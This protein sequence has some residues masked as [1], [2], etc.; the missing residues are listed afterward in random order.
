MTAKYV[1]NFKTRK[2]APKNICELKWTVI[3]KRK[4]RKPRTEIYLMNR[5]KCIIWVGFSWQILRWEGCISAFTKKRMKE[6]E[7]Q[8]VEI[9]VRMWMWIN[10]I[11][12]HEKVSYSVAIV[13]ST[14]DQNGHGEELEVTSTFGNVLF[15]FF[16]FIFFIESFE[17]LET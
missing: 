11:N 7:E 9:C 3:L 10:L 13:A 8:A 4:K 12:W 14:S 15:C 6:E 17:K 1:G 2:Q 5:V 16:T